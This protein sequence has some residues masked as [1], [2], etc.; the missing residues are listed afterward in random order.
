MTDA[1]SRSLPEPRNWQDFERLTFDVFRR[2]WK[3]TDADLHGRTGQPQNG[4]DVYGTDY[5]SDP[6]FGRFTGIQCKG[7]DAGY[8]GAVT[9]SELRAEVEKALGFQPPLDVFVLATTAPNDVGIQ[10]AA[11]AISQEHRLLGKFE[12]RVTGWETLR[13]Y[14]TDFPDVLSKHFADL[15]PINVVEKIDVV[16]TE[17]AEGLRRIETLFSGQRRM[18]ADFLETGREVD[19]LAM[20]V[21]EIA[22][23]IGEGAPQIALKTLERLLTENEATA[24]DV[25]KFRLLANIGNAHLAMGRDAEAI[26]FFERAGAAYPDYPNALATLAFARSLQ[27]RREEALLLAKEALKRDS[28][29]R[30]AAGVVVDMEPS[31]VAVADIAAGLPAEVADSWEVAVGLSMRAH[32]SGDG[33]AALAYAEKALA[34]QPDDWRTLSTVADALL[35]PLEPLD[36]TPVTGVVDDGLRCRLERAIELNR[37]AWDILERQE[38]NYL[39][40]HVAANLIVQLLLTQQDTDAWRVLD[41]AIIQHPDYVPLLQCQAQR[42][43]RQGAWGSAS[44]SLLRIP[45]AERTFEDALL[46]SHSALAIKDGETVSLACE[47]LASLAV[48]SEQR[49]FAAAVNV[50]ANISNG[51]DPVATI[52]DLL[53]AEP[54][55]II[56][57]SELFE[58]IPKDHFL[59]TDV[60]AQIGSLGRAAMSTRS[61]VLAAETMMEAGEFSQA[62]D[63]YEPLMS[64][65]D[66]SAVFRRLQALH[67]ADRRKE[68]RALYE[69]L[70]ADVRKRERY[71]RLGAAVYERAGLLQPAKALLEGMFASSESLIGRLQW[72]QLQMRLGETGFL[73]WLRSVPSDL[74]AEPR[75]LVQLAQFIDKFFP[76]DFRALELGYRALRAGYGDPQVHLGYAFALFFFGSA[77]RSEIVTP[78]TV[79]VG[80]GVVLRGEESGD[81]LF[82]LIEKRGNAAAERGELE[83]DNPVAISLTGCR[84]GELIE[85]PNL[86]LGASTYRIAEVH[87]DYVFAFQ[88]T[89]REFNRLFPGHPALGSLKLDPSVEPDRQFE[90]VFAVAR[91]RAERSVELTRVYDTAVLP[92][93][94][95][96]RFA[97]TDIYDLWEGLRARPGNFLKVAL[98]TD[99]E[100][101]LGAKVASDGLA[102][103]DP[104]SIYAWVRLG[105]ADVMLKLRER[106]GVVQSTIDLLRQLHAEREA[107]QGQEGGIF[108]W[109]GEHYHFSKTT[110][111]VVE[112]RIVDSWAAVS[113]AQALVLVPAEGNAVLPSGVRDLF[114][115]VHPAFE[116]TLIAALGDK[117]SLLTDDLGLRVLAQAFSVPCTWTQTF[118]QANALSEGLSA[119]D[120]Q[121]LLVALID[122]R[123][124]F[125]Q[126][127]HVDVLAALNASGWSLDGRVRSFAGLMARPNVDAESLSTVFAH[128]LVDS[129]TEEREAAAFA[130][131]FGAYVDAL[132]EAGSPLQPDTIFSR[133]IQKVEGTI[134]KLVIDR[135]YRSELRV[136]SNLTSPENIVSDFK[137]VARNITLKIRG[138][139]SDGGIQLVSG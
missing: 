108:G 4:V 83:P 36:A 62:A 111:E 93:S 104:L 112:Q 56:V 69:S 60:I 136:S 87:S 100:M 116:D 48:T 72:I 44:Q 37:K 132:K 95:M 25:A 82:Y 54:H 30:R 126:I 64:V 75:E 59:R 42:Y 120:Y 73:D 80:T 9:E 24:S 123:Y 45:A 43:A 105:I 106:L 68:A 85:I 27:G 46:L 98:G 122:S 134:L 55:S 19:P 2:L 6:K 47:Q 117:R 103:V 128:L 8:G 57:R 81:E 88:R 14:I 65:S 63:L 51:S 129:F 110:P 101:K 71:V 53:G 139:L 118:V 70:P 1:L 113:L 133:T 74:I 7:K 79:E 109:D 89:L 52:S 11:R 29:L 13:Q 76:G 99:Q 107:D 77:R 18:I 125:T 67:G 35:A 124:D 102:V 135:Q 114:G 137:V 49:E 50:R 96:A 84:A 39:G 33:D 121:R 20:A 94:L 78:A 28:S 138:K 97:G 15:A 92:L 40:R 34:L 31:E 131:F 130:V 3:T 17:N 119:E 22:S 16:R 58:E 115:D 91:Q 23:Q 61:R 21:T 41:Q 90:P 26:G 66:S 12:V 10:A 127:G 5:S 86:V 32:R 38:S